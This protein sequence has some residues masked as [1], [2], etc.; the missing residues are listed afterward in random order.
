MV[1]TDLAV[2]AIDR[3]AGEMRLT[4]LAP[5]MTLEEVKARTDADFTHG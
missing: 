4:E 3:K 5:G 1:I 2:F